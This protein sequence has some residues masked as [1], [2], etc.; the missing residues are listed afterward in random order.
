MP[1]LEPSPEFQSPRQVSPRQVPGKEVPRVSLEPLGGTHSSMGMWDLQGNATKTT[2][3]G[4]LGMEARGM[5]A[6]VWFAL[7][8]SQKN[9]NCPWGA[10]GLRAAKNSPREQRWME[11]G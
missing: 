3:Q 8:P 5:R 2:L 6:G 4:G 7:E 10:P 11:L 9:H 1:Y